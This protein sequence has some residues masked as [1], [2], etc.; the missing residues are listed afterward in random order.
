M[1]SISR[2]L[3]LLVIALVV[4]AG[5]CQADLVVNATISNSGSAPIFG[6]LA[7]EA[8]GSARPTPRR[9]QG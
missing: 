4:S 3:G 9:L 6:T 1:E 5:P 7:V 2:R 8:L